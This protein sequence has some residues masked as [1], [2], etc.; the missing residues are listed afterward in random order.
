VTAAEQAAENVRAAHATEME[1]ARK[2]RE[3]LRKW[4]PSTLRRLSRTLPKV[5][6][7]LAS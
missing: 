7:N 2:V 3:A 6:R 4:I 5:E 1:R